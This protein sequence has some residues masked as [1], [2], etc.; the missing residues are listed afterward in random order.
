MYKIIDFL[1]QCYKAKADIKT[2]RILKPIYKKISEYILL[3]EKD[4]KDYN[5]DI[6]LTKNII[7]DQIHFVY[8]IN[9]L[10][11]GY[12]YSTGLSPHEAYLQTLYMLD[13]K[14]ERTFAKMIL[15]KKY[16]ILLSED[17]KIKIKYYY[18]LINSNDE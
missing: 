13:T 2:H 7:N 18:S 14:V 10:Y 3:I 15:D 9:L 6:V 1:E 12:L 4:I 11:M 8:I 5:F 17:E 16:F